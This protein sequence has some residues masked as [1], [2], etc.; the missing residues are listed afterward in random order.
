MEKSGPWSKVLEKS[1]DDSRQQQDPLP[2]QIFSL[3]RRAENLPRQDYNLEESLV[4]QFLKFDLL[5]WYGSGG[6][7]QYLD[8]QNEKEGRLTGFRQLSQAGLRLY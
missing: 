5:D 6:G 3:E 1:L 4:A 8:I 7:L 2:V